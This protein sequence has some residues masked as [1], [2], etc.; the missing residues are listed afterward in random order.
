M[1]FHKTIQKYKYAEITNFQEFQKQY[2]TTLNYSGT[3]WTYIISKTSGR[4]KVYKPDRLDFLSCLQPRFAHN[5][6]VIA[7]VEPD[8]LKEKLELTL[9]SI[10]SQR[11]ESFNYWN[12]ISQS[13][14]D[15]DNPLIVVLQI[16][17]F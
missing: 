16:K 3:S 1:D 2:F 5:G 15:S 9:P 4:H 11:K 8:E 14:D 12:N 7:I 17:D 10:R 13:L 6:N